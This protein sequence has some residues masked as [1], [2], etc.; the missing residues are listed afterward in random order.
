MRG[1]FDAARALG[2]SADTVAEELGQKLWLAVGGM[3]VWEIE[4]LAGD[5]SAAELAARRACELLEEL[6]D[7]AHRASAAG[8]LA[9]SLLALGRLDEADESTRTSEALSASDDVV[10]HMLWRQVRAQVLAHRGEEAVAERLA[11]EAVSLAEDTDMLNSHG[12][13]LA[14]LAEVYV[15]AGRLDEGRMN[16]EQALALYERKGN[17]VAAAKARGRLDDLRAV[18]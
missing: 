11:R 9:A 1:N 5:P 4:M 14:A 15:L 7:T 10:S 18:S 17:V 3:A 6:G 8:E 13:A 12:N 16:L 2:R